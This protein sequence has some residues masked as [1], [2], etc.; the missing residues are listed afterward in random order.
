MSDIFIR[1]EDELM[2]EIMLP[3]RAM[4]FVL[5]PHLACRSLEVVL[6]WRWGGGL[7]LKVRLNLE[8]TLC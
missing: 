6:C 1:R 2:E 3:G 5:G 4:N 7:R 8:A